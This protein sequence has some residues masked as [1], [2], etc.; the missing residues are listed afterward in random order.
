[1][2][3]FDAE[4]AQKV[5]KKSKSS[6]KHASLVPIKLVTNGNWKNVS[7][8]VFLHQKIKGGGVSQKSQEKV[9]VAW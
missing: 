5:D 1:M 3:M 8:T 9:K 2:L 7:C 4:E 6:K